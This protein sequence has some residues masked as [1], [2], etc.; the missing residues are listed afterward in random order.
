MIKIVLKFNGA[1]V[2][3]ELVVQEETTVGRKPE[4]DVVIDN[5]AVSG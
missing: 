3:E 5:P 1:V 4:N 2:K